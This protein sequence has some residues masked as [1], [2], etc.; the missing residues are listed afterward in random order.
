MAVRQR[1][2]EKGGTDMSKGPNPHR[3]KQGQSGGKKISK[4]C[5]VFL[6][7]FAFFCSSGAGILWNYYTSMRMYS[8]LAVQKAVDMIRDTDEDLQRLWGTYR[9]AFLNYGGL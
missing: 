7:L 2:P 9:L 1:K 6:I 5:Q 4:A 3:R 8:P